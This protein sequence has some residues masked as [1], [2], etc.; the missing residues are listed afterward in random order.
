VNRLLPVVVAA[1]LAGAA[2]AD[3]RLSG[4]HWRLTGFQ[5]MDDAIG[6]V[7]PTDPALYTMAL[8]PDGSVSMRLN[9]NRATGTWTAQPAADGTSGSFS[10]GPLATTR[11]LCPPPSMDES[12]A[13]H[14]AHVRGFLLRDGKL[15]L[16]LEADAGIYTWEPDSAA[17]AA[18]T[19]AA[20]GES[21]ARH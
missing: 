10:F 7:R 15:H 9:C 14:S 17:A 3:D 20:P 19:P 8:N 16:S 13:T 2:H 18:E 11:A 12:I 6:T 4:T 21:G 1:L 5:S